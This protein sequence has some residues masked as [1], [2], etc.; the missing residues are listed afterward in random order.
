MPEPTHALRRQLWLYRQRKTSIVNL[1]AKL[2]LA[3]AG[4]ILIDDRQIKEVTS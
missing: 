3:N 2:Y 4:E 1:V